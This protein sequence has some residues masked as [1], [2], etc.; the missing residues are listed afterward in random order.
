MIQKLEHN[1][2][3]TTDDFSEIIDVESFGGADIEA[4]LSIHSMSGTTPLLS[5]TPQY[6]YDQIE[7]FDVPAECVFDPASTAGYE[8]IKLPF[9]GGYIRFHYVLSGTAPLAEFDIFVRLAVGGNSVGIQLKSLVPGGGGGSTPIP[10]HFDASGTVEVDDTANPTGTQI[11]PANSD[12][13]VCELLNDGDFD[14]FYGSGSI[15]GD[16][17]KILS[18]QT[19]SFFGVEALKVLSPDG[20]VNIRYI[21]YS[22]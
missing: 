12:R 18:G 4:T 8:T 5:V 22:Y 7:W 3:G 20:N 1:I 16:F 13:A 17:Q 11:V 21:D 15:A 14:A 19:K 2:S 6:S 10:V 9:V